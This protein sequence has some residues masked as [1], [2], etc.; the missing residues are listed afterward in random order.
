LKG[1]A[2]LRCLVC[3]KSFRVKKTIADKRKVCSIVCRNEYLRDRIKLRCA[4]CGTEYTTVKGRRNT[5]KYCSRT[6]LHKSKRKVKNPPGKL[7]LEHLVTRLTR[8]E[9]AGLYGIHPSLVTRWC[10]KYGVRMLTPSER[11]EFKKHSNK[12]SVQLPGE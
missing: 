9:I 6:C 3:S 7:Q 12:G 4:L 10:H 11:A 5:S 8:K 2:D 1:S